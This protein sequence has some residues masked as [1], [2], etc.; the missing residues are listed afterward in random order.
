M[1]LL[2]M[3]KNRKIMVLWLTVLN[4]SCYVILPLSCFFQV[5]V[6]LIAFRLK[7]FTHKFEVSFVLSQKEWR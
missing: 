6:K 4:F 5:I 2:H 1:K 3:N 7:F